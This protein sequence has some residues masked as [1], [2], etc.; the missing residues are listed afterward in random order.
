MERILTISALAI[1][2]VCLVLDSALMEV[3]V[4][5]KVKHKFDAVNII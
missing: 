4:G 5:N 2:Q 1:V 3:F